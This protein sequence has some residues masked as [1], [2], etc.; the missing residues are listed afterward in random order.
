MGGSEPIRNRQRDVAIGRKLFAQRVVALTFSCPK[1]TAVD[2]YDGGERSASLPRH[3]QVQT[4]RRAAWAGVFD[5]F[6]PGHRIGRSRQGAG[7][8][9][10]AGD[11]DEH[12]TEAAK[13][14]G[15]TWVSKVRASGSPAPRASPA[16]H[17]DTTTV[18]A[19]PAAHPQRL[20][21][22]NGLERY[23]TRSNILSK[24][25]DPKA[26]PLLDLPVHSGPH[27]RHGINT[28]RSRRRD[29]RRPPWPSDPSASRR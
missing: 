10:Q 24:R 23:L 22:D 3:R 14:V 15:H 12:G 2:A 8:T 11:T 13:D 7:R 28:C 27:E 19:F 1:A 21:S 26:A 25:G 4:Q 17:K 6:M 5:A 18:F 20:R 9:G 29:R 16:A